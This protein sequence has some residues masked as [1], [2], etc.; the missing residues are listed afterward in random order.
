MKMTASWDTAPCSLVEVDC[1]QGA[2]MMEAG[3]TSNTP[4]YF[5]ETTR[6][7]IADGCHLHNH[8]CENLKS[9]IDTKVSI[10]YLILEDPVASKNV[11]VF[12]LYFA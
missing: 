7:C 12:S 4:V 1:L 8:R 9:H 3:R 11:Y 10:G 2:L 5:N 6:P